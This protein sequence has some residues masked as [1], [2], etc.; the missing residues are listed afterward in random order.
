MSRRSRFL[1]ALNHQN[2]DAVPVDFGSTSVTGIHVSVVEAL[3]AH[4]GL[5]AGPVKVVEP[6][7]M[8]GELDVG[9]LDAMGVDV[10][11]LVPRMTMFGF[12]NEG[13]R[14]FRM[15]WGQEV[16]VPEGFKTS[17]QANGD[18]LMHP[19]GDLS[20][21]PSARMPYN[22]FFFDTISRQPPIDEDRLDP[23]DNLE[24]FQPVRDD[25]VR[26]FATELARLRVGSRGVIATFGGTAFGD[27]ALIPAPFLKNP[28]GIRDV[29]EWYVSTVSRRDYIHCVFQKQCEIAI[30]NLARL[31]AEIG[32]AIDAVFICGTDFGTQNSCFCSPDTFE[33]LYAPYYSA[34]NDWIHKHTAWKTFKHSCGAVEPFMSSFIK[35][36]FDIVNP[37]QCSA[38]GMDPLRLKEQYGE[39]IVF[40]GGGVD[41]QSTLPFGTPEEVR[42]QVLD[43]C[44][45]FSEQGGF[46]FNT[47]HNVQAKTP[48]DNVV[49]MLEAVQEFN[50]RA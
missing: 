17:R 48:V 36:G 7:Q 39:D 31:F 14:P 40:W 34:V 16:L 37:V 23:E 22:G 47:V 26:H 13:W 43:R 12:P 29:E 24:E 35:A 33:E 41:T 21:P 49:A 8:L 2:S 9:L 45:L 30:K 15:P 1:S 6:Y 46:V 50:G 4:Y 18:L 32:D 42:A 44:E 28:K 27:I 5:E 3:R 20:A 38:S 11:G 10:V 25:D 19:C